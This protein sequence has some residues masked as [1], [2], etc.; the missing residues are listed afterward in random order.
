MTRPA[1]DRSAIEAL[2]ARARRDV[3]DGLLPSCQIALARDGELLVDETYGA[4]PASR[5]VT[6]SVT[7]AL[8][9]ALAWLLM[10]DGRLRDD[11]RVAEVVPEFAANDKDAVTV[12]HLL[13]HTAAFHR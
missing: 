7:K 2:K 9:A 5:Y 3:D 1:A 6:F 8:T 11:T 12:E 10:G 13:C 4:P